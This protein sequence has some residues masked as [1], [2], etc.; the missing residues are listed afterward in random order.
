VKAVCVKQRGGDEWE[1]DFRFA[2][3]IARFD[4]LPHG[5]MTSP[6]QQYIDDPEED[7]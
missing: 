2:K 5:P 1:L 3:E 6:A 4:D 7:S